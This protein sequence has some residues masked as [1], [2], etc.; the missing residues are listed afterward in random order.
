MFLNV[1]DSCSLRFAFVNRLIVTLCLAY[2]EGAWDVRYIRQC[3]VGPRTLVGAEA[4]KWCQQRVGT[5]RVKMRICYCDNKDGCNV[6]S[7]QRSYILTPVLA[8]FTA[9]FCAHTRLFG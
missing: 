1:I 7:I 9:Y 2:Y 3:A 4:G 5:Y 6:A 8:A